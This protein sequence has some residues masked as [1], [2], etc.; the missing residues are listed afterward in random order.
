M[1]IKKNQYYSPVYL[2]GTGSGNLPL[3]KKTEFTFLSMRDL[4]T[5]HHVAPMIA[6]ADNGLNG[7]YNNGA[8]QSFGEISSSHFDLNEIMCYALK[9]LG[10]QAHLHESE[11]FNLI[12]FHCE[13]KFSNILGMVVK[14]LQHRQMGNLANLSEDKLAE[15]REKLEQTREDILKRWTLFYIVTRYIKKSASYQNSSDNNSCEMFKIFLYDELYQSI[16]SD[17]L[18]KS[19]E[20]KNQSLLNISWPS[21]VCFKDKQIEG[22]IET[23]NCVPDSSFASMLLDVKDDRAIFENLSY[24]VE[25]E[26]FEHYIHIISQADTKIKELIATIIDGLSNTQLEWTP[27]EKDFVTSS[28]PIILRLNKSD[29]A[30]LEEVGYEWRSKEPLKLGKDITQVYTDTEHVTYLQKFFVQ[31]NIEVT[32]YDYKLLQSTNPSTGINERKKFCGFFPQSTRSST[33][34]S[35][36]SSEKQI[37]IS[38][39]NFPQSTS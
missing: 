21:Y 15:I 30:L 17:F 29:T 24:G 14:I 6:A 4:V 18:Q 3:L 9:T 25:D 33:H 36:E 26:N 1:D 28:F 11:L 39:N 20:E 38:P 7:A 37:G 22:G 35:E 12:K 19:D 27:E 32:I 16:P 10:N 13:T 8:C 2:H 34:N 5:K 23:P 31:N